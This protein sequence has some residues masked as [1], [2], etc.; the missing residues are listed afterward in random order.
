MSKAIYICSR[1]KLPGSTRKRLTAI[2]ERLA[3]DNITPT[4]PRV[5]TD[6]HNA[7]AVLNPSGSIRESGNSVMIGEFFGVSEGWT[8][9]GRPSP[10]GGYAL[11]RDGPDTLEFV[12]DPASTRTIWYAFYGD[13][14]IA[15]TSQRAIVMYLGDFEFDER[16]I[17]WMLSSGTLGPTHSWDKRLQRIPADSSITL[18]KGSWALTRNDHPVRFSAS[19]ESDDRHR[20][21]VRDALVGTCQSLSLDFSRWISG[22]SGGVDSRGV[23]LALREVGAPIGQMEAITWGRKIDWEEQGN[24]ATVAREVAREIGIRHRSYRF[25][26]SRDSPDRIIDRFL[27]RGEGRL[28]QLAGFVDGFELWRVL[29]DDGYLGLLRADHPF[30]NAHVETAAQARHLI[31][32]PLC[33]DFSNLRDHEKY[34]FQKHA[35]PE[36]L[37]QREDESV[38]TYRDRLYHAFRVPT[39]LSAWNEGRHCYIETLCPFLSRA[40]IEQARRMPD[41]LRTRKETYRGVIGAWGP[42]I[43]LSTNDA[44][45]SA[46]DFIVQPEVIDLMRRELSSE[47]ARSVLPAEFLD[48][49]L[50]GLPPKSLLGKVRRRVARL[51]KPPDR[52]LPKV[53]RP[54]L[55]F[56][57]FMISRMARLLREDSDL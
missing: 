17:P 25:E 28:D 44:L 9:P 22:L 30:G 54:I 40:C 27:A 42:A 48:D 45:A 14:L 35:L 24:D 57:A 8:T 52:T 41:R 21:L 33:S 50:A 47:S 6:T 51:A 18:D 2:C 55:A 10:D 19:D 34:G 43:A 1:G 37:V 15:S 32:C 13:T 12:S 16:V 3:P 20:E 23:L 49:A 38:V 11:F 39:M 4:P 56:R 46:R 53:S 26:Q 29:F 31:G 7:Y 5:S 36:S